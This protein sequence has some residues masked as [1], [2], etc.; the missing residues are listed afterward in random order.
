MSDEVQSVDESIKIL[1]HYEP[2][3]Y[4]ATYD[5]AEALPKP[6]VLA[7][8]RFLVGQLPLPQ[9]AKDLIVSLATELL[10]GGDLSQ[11]LRDAVYAFAKNQLEP[12]RESSPQI[13]GAVLTF[14]VKVLKPTAP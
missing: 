5:G 8:L 6:I 3:S 9:F 11:S 7:A 10:N 1:E 12:F 4:A 13:V 2:A 14:L